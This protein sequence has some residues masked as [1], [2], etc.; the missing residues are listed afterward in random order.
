MERFE[1]RILSLTRKKK[2]VA[3]E[4]ELF[5]PPVLAQI[6]AE[7]TIAGRKKILGEFLESPSDYFLQ[8]SADDKVKAVMLVLRFSLFIAFP[9]PITPVYIRWCE[10]VLQ[11]CFEMQKFYP[12]VD[13]SFAIKRVFE[14]RPELEE[15][16]LDPERS[17]ARHFA[18]FFPREGVSLF[19]KKGA[20][21]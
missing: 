2:G 19:S 18:L 10:T 4:V 3:K 12:N 20:T 8:L 1:K 6:V 5:L 7:Y 14:H 13:V 17:A 21:S 16:W 9:V 11:K 15:D